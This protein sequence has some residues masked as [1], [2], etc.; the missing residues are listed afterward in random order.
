MI[1]IFKAKN[2]SLSAKYNDI[3][4]HSQYNPQREAERFLEKEWDMEKR[5]LIIL[6]ACMGHLKT[7]AQRKAPHSR[8]LCL[9]FDK[10]FQEYNTACSCWHPEKTESLRDF[11]NR[12]ISA[13]TLKDIQILVWPPAARTC[14]SLLENYQNQIKTFFQ[15]KTSNL[16]T[17]GFFARRWIRNC[18]INFL[19]IEKISYFSRISGLPLICAAGPGLNQS[20][21][22]IKEF[23]QNLLICALPSSLHCLEKEGI[24][25]DLAVNTDAGYWTSLHFQFIKRPKQLASSLNSYPVTSKLKLNPVLFTQ[26][27]FM[28]DYLIPSLIKNKEDINKIVRIPSHG[29][30]SGSSFFLFRHWK[31]LPL[32]FAGL[33]LHYQDIQAHCR[34]HSFDAL[35]SSQS[36][37]FSPLQGIYFQR[38]IPNS[39]K[40]N[41]KKLLRSSLPLKLYLDWFRDYQEKHPHQYFNLEE[42]SNGLASISRKE[43]QKL[44]KKKAKANWENKTI[45]CISYRQKQEVLQLLFKKLRGELKEL[46]RS[47]EKAFFPEKAENSLAAILLNELFP[48]KLEKAKRQFWQESRERGENIKQNCLEEALDFIDLLQKQCCARD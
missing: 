35:F 24:I 13:D 37:R 17:S 33:D 45:P 21:P 20:L 8:I 48:L 41:P 32:C 25:P 31:E 22:L 44:L 30:V 18:L 42:S 10:T 12:E 43:L 9:L 4:L 46:S 19:L 47:S 11:L 36:C 14:Q 26:G 39:H 28:E 3:Y 29:T 7:A 15:E 5:I 16:L 27:F 2:G 34:P 1:S 38:N 6:G 23:R 40:I